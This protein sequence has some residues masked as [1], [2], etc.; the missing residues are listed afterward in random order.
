MNTDEFNLM[1]QEIIAGNIETVDYINND[2]QGGNSSIQIPQLA[3]ALMSP[4]N[5]VRT[6]RIHNVRPHFYLNNILPI[7]IALQHVNN[8]VTSLA[9]TR[10]AFWPDGL[11]ALAQ[12][13]QHNNNRITSLE[14]AET[15][16]SPE[17]FAALAPAFQHENT[18]VTSLNLGDIIAIVGPPPRWKPND[19]PTAIAECIL[20]LVPALQHKNNRITELYYTTNLS[21]IDQDRMQAIK[22]ILREKRVSQR[23]AELISYQ[24]LDD[25]LLFIPKDLINLIKAYHVEL[26]SI[27]EEREAREKAKKAIKHLTESSLFKSEEAQMSTAV[28]LSQQEAQ[29]AHMNRVSS[30]SPSSSSSVSSSQTISQTEPVIFINAVR[31][32]NSTSIQAGNT[33]GSKSE[34]DLPKPTKAELRDIHAKRFS[35]K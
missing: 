12:V 2:V 23:A 26:S 4:G 19:D 27:S 25:E 15:H 10:A 29:N 20:T 17:Y 33:L 22:N 3:E 9:F 7:F 32:S 35:K 28:D 34:S 16:I 24:I 14:L 30:F 21:D 1:I 6:L 31:L 18:R 11:Q 13:L 5:R 8:C